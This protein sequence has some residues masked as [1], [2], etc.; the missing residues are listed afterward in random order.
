V[1]IL[2]FFFPVFM[3]NRIRYTLK[4]YEHTLGSKHFPSLYNNS[5][6]GLAYSILSKGNEILAPAFIDDDEDDADC[7]TTSGCGQQNL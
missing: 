7:I 4:Y 3:L 5:S 2:K 6:H 1:D